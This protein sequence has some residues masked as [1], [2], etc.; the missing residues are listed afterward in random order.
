MLD[1]RLTTTSSGTKRRSPAGGTPLGRAWPRPPVT[2]SP[3]RVPFASGSAMVLSTVEGTELTV[4]ARASGRGRAVVARS[5]ASLGAAG[6]PIRSGPGPG[7]PLPA[8][9]PPPPLPPIET[10]PMPMPPPPPPSP[11]NWAWASAGGS[12]SSNSNAAARRSCQPA[13][14]HLPRAAPAAAGIV[15]ADD[16][17]RSPSQRH[18]AGVSPTSDRSDHR[19]P[20]IGFRRKREVIVS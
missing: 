7:K 16:I 17:A 13:A 14:G 8:P 15:G 19:L 6:R 9:R 4:G 3:I 2:R 11:P 1:G 20:A 18:E 10:P 5:I 12:A